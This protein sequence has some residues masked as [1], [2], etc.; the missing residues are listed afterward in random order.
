MSRAALSKS[1]TPAYWISQ[2]NG[3][4]KSKESLKTAATTALKTV[5]SQ[6]KDIEWDALDLSKLTVAAELAKRADEL[7]KIDEAVGKLAKQV[8]VAIEA[9]K[10][11]SKALSAAD[12]KIADTVKSIES[13]GNKLVAEAKSDVATAL[14]TLAAKQAAAA[15]AQAAKGAAAAPP[16][17]KKALALGMSYRK[18]ALKSMLNA[19]SKP[20]LKPARFM[21]VEF[22]TQVL[23]YMGLKYDKRMTENAMKALNHAKYPD[24]PFIK[25]Y[26]DPN[27]KVIWEK[28][29]L[30]LVSDRIKTGLATRISKSSKI[31]MGKTYK[32]RMRKENGEAVESDNHEAQDVSEADLA[33]ELAAMAPDPEADNDVDSVSADSHEDDD[34]DKKPAAAAAPIDNKAAVAVRTLW[35]DAQKSATAEVDALLT[36]I[37]GL[38]PKGEHQ[39]ALDDAEHTL[40][41]LMGVFASLDDQLKL[42]A[43]QK[44]KQGQEKYI[45]DVRNKVDALRQLEKHPVM[46]SLDDN[47]V[48]KIRAGATLF[49]GLDKVDAVMK[50]L[51]TR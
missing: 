26:V 51:A 35:A 3:S 21:V 30:T 24:D 43:V 23:V 47:E 36:Q 42:V 17:D 29:T 22:K 8:D 38:F 37:R 4:D 10:K 20:Q 11:F 25:T 15:A 39:K 5:E 2:T 34:G 44:D 49:A 31:V 27:S 48:H 14:K 33:K 6:N 12:K 45:R 19:R 28:N 9:A 46:K 32:I 16:V 18:L 1:L 7:S 41:H 13:D 40:R 50:S